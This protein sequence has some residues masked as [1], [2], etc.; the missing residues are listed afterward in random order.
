MASLTLTWE[1]PSVSEVS[2]IIVGVLLA[3]LHLEFM[4]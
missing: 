4:G 3:I 1:R 2:P